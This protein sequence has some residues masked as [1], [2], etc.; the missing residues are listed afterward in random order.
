MSGRRYTEAKKKKICELYRD[1]KKS[2]AAIARM[3]GMPTEKT[4]RRILAEKGVTTRGNPRKYDREAIL[5]DLKTNPVAKVAKKHG[6][7]E[8]FIYKIKP[9]KKDKKKK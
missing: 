9:K 3:R 5:R 1:D 2:A 8:R 6:C 4:V 7:S